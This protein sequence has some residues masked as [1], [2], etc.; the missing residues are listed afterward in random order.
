M[1]AITST[2]VNQSLCALHRMYSER[3]FVGRRNSSPW[4]WSYRKNRGHSQGAVQRTDVRWK[5]GYVRLPQ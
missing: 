3:W 5:T 4:F 2:N 1:G